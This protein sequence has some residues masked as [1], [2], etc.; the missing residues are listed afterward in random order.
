MGSLRRIL[1]AR[2]ASPAVV[3][4][5]TALVPLLA[6]AACGDDAAARARGEL[7]RGRLDR[8]E[9]LA[10]TLEPE[11]ARAV[12]AEVAERRAD[13]ERVA[14]AVE[15]ELAALDRHH[16]NRVRARL[17]DL[18]ERQSDPVSREL[19]ERA[20]SELPDHARR[21]ASASDAAA[22]PAPDGAASAWSPPAESSTADGT[23][24]AWVAD[25]GDVAAVDADAGA[26]FSHPP[27]V[28]ELDEPDGSPVIDGA[29]AASVARLEPQRAARS[30]E[31]RGDLERAVAAWREAAADEPLG[32]ER[33]RCLRR[34]RDLEARMALY[35]ELAA[36]V[37]SRRLQRAAPGARGADADGLELD[38]ER[39]TWRTLPV[40][41]LWRLAQA[42]PLSAFAED[43]LLGLVLERGDERERRAARDAVRAAVAAGR[44][45]VERGEILLGAEPREATA[46]A[47]PALPVS[48]WAEELV[49]ADREQADGLLEQL[50][51][52]GADEPA[53]TALRARWGRALQEVLDGP[54]RARLE[55][56]A[57]SRRALD[58]A[59]AAALE[60]IFDTNE[61]FYP[62]RPPACP[63][64]RARLYPAVQRRVDELVGA[65][66]DAWRTDR[67]VSLPD[68]FRDALEELHWLRE[69]GRRVAG[70]SAPAKETPE[71]LWGLP[72]GVDAVDLHTFGWTDEERLALRRSAAIRAYNRGLWEWAEDLADEVR[73]PR[74]SER[75]QVEITN[76]YRVMFGRSALAWSPLLQESA[77]LQADYM[78]RTGDF[79][80]YQDEPELR[81]PRDRMAHVGYPQP[82]SENCATGTSDPQSAHDDWRGSSGHHRNLLE[83][84]HT[85]MASALAATYW[86]QNF[87][88]DVSFEEELDPWSD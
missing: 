24:T 80:H 5:A 61:Y 78:S 81:T 64:E 36:A 32:P 47:A 30:H 41:D 26:A 46:D 3:L 55:R 65:V 82:A 44:L 71:W 13:R 12:L 43:G 88:R 66:R 63:P 75:R 42:A 67:S 77:R 7:A 60:L 34:A 39:K 40:K 86:A 18:L 22:A 57:E 68:G 58:D 1:R 28:A 45:P 8:A 31:A 59:R 11:Q 49:T 19:V 73:S 56:L 17:R 6:L 21:A 2:A 51:D 16:E 72:L 10:A 62:Y 35:G 14:A 69:R 76:D 23:G 9:S 15:E 27:P 83:A 85:E 70:W 29:D 52:A 48:R 50:V 79:G 20:L 25:D 84:E 4:R 37:E 53:S 54:T 33:E 38:G 74:W 87:G